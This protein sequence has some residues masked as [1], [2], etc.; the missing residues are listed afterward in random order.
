LE[1]KKEIV[2]DADGLILGRLASYAAKLALQGNRIKIINAEKA[3]IS[4]NKRSIINEWLAH[5]EIKSKIHP[6]HTPIHYRRP[7][8]ILKRVIRGMLPRKKPKG[9]ESLKRIKVYIGIPKELENVKPINL[10][11]AKA[12]RPKVFYLSLGELAKELGWKYG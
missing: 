9:R 5:L 11:G 2:I 6:K 3:L 4:G 10:E 12:K 7:D 1:D 8:K